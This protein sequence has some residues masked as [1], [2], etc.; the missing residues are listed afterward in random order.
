MKLTLLGFAGLLIGSV[1]LAAD[2]GRDMLAAKPEAVEKWKNMRFGMFI[3]WGPVSLTGRE[4]P[5]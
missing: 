5:P 2:P 3:C 4:K 1:C